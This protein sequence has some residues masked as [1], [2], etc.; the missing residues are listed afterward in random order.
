VQDGDHR[1]PFAVP[2]AYQRR[3][4]PNAG[5]IDRAVGLVEQHQRRILKQDPG[6]VRALQLTARERADRTPLEA[7]QADQVDRRGNAL[8][9]GPVEAAKGADL[10]PQA[11]GHEVVNDHRKAAV[12]RRQLGQVSDLL[13]LHADAGRCGPAAVAVRRQ[14]P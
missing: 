2:V 13:A 7:V 12:E 3:Q 8:A 4:I 1:P 11:H 9:P 10:A 5:G 6:E 14:C